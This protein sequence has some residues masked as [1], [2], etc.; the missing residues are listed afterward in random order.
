[1][2]FHHG[3]APGSA[4]GGSRFSFPVHVTRHGKT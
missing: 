1:V 3:V 4:E 2:K